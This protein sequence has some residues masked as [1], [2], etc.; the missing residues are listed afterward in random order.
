MK[1]GRRIFRTLTFCEWIYDFFLRFYSME[2]RGDELTTTSKAVS[3]FSAASV[4]AGCLRW[5]ACG[6]CVVLVVFVLK[7][8]PC[9]DSK[10]SRV[11]RQSVHVSNTR[12]CFDGTRG[13]RFGFTRGNIEAASL[14][15]QAT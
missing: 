5:L 1:L 13:G 10:R 11:C 14:Q 15:R 6:V 3:C 4:C 9:A 8:P 7:T 2:S 12:G